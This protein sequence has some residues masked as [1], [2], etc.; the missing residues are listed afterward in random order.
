VT[1]E[2]PVAGPSHGFFA[3]SGLIMA[4]ILAV[5][6]LLAILATWARPTP[7]DIWVGLPLVV[8]GGLLRA[9]SVGYLLKTRQLAITGPYAFTR[10][11]LY[12]GRLL[13]FTGFAIMA[14]LPSRANLG[15]LAGGLAIFFIYYMPRKERIECARLRQTH[16]EEYARYQAA[17][18]AL[19]PR[20]TPYRGTGDAGSGWQWSRFHRNREYMMLILEAGLVGLFAARAFG[21]A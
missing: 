4:R 1:A 10:N 16:G 6:A 13:L 8:A 12:L 2:T 3:K 21:W 17:V 14:T 9:W 20:L 7:L 11:P 5:F 15:I 19:F 18:S